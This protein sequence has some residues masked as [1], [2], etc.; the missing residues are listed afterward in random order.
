MKLKPGDLVKPLG[1]CGGELGQTRCDVALVIET[2]ASS[3]PGFDQTR[4]KIL[5]PCGTDE[6]YQWRYEK[7]THDPTLAYSADPM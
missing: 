6:D 5:C 2:P 4:A 7:I 1:R 3:E